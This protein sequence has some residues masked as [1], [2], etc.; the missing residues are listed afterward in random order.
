[1]LASLIALIINVLANVLLVPSF[2]AGGAAV[3]TCL[4]FWAFLILRTEFSI[5][6]WKTMPRFEMYFFT[7]LCLAGASVSALAGE[8]MKYELLVY[9]A[10]LLV[11]VLLRNLQFLK[12]LAKR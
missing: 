9:W 6:S 2:G 4:A 7:F 1:M 5:I 12:S 11:V 8:R 10:T 3:S